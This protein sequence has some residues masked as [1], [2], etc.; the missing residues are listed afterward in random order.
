MISDGFY[1]VKELRS[2]KI[3]VS[4]VIEADNFFNDIKIDDEILEVNNTKAKNIDRGEI[5][6]LKSPLGLNFNIK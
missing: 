2:N 4:K 5:D 6:K 3:V 1:L